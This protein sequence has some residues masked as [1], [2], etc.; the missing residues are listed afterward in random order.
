MKSRNNS[1]MDTDTIFRTMR[2]ML[3]EAPPEEVSALAQEAGFDPQQL[4][5]A[6]RRLVKSAI[7]QCKQDT[8]EDESVL[9]L[10]KGLN[11]LLVMLRRRDGL[12]EGELAQKAD[13]DE[14]EIRR[15]EFDTSYLPSPRSIYKLEEAFGLPPGVLA[16]TFRRHQKPISCFGEA[17]AG[18]C[19]QREIYGA[20]HES[21]ARPAERICT[22]LDGA[23]LNIPMA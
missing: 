18:V 15:I 14:E 6:G 8:T 9:F 19:R 12:D 17:G 10:H 11:S 2:E 7:Q 4:A 21:R 22:I 3:L 5:H 20:T 23:G 13:I 16:K 1:N